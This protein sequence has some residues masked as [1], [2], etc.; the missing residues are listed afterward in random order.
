[1]TVLGQT[2]QT[3]ITGG[4][5]FIQMPA[6]IPTLMI[7]FPDTSTSG[8]RVANSADALA[9]E[10]RYLAKDLANSASDQGPYSLVEMLNML[11][12]TYFDGPISVRFDYSIYDLVNDLGLDQYLNRNDLEQIDSSN[13]ETILNGHRFKRPIYGHNGNDNLTGT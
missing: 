10:L 13:I 6:F 12:I 1:M 5:T 4:Q 8:D 9:E 3:L 2:N 11:K 7:C